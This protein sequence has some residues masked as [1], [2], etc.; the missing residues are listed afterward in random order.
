MIEEYGDMWTMEAD[1]KCVTTNG[2]VKKGGG[3]VMG[4]GTAKQ[5]AMRAPIVP[6]WLGQLIRRNGNHVQTISAH[7][8]ETGTYTLV[9]FPVK[10]NWWEKADLKLIERSLVELNYLADMGD[11]KKILLPRPGCGNGQ[12]SWSK[13]VKKLVEPVLDDR[14]VVVDY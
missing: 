9:A 11:W 7:T 12:L 8:D 13:Q 2:T 10:H 1:V 14:F 3:A 4:R 6:T 5:A